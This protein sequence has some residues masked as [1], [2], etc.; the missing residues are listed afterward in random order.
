M[1]LGTGSVQSPAPSRR[2]D[3]VAV[4]AALD[5]FEEAWQHGTPPRLLD[6]LPADLETA[7][8]RDILI[9][10]IKID[11]DN[12]WRRFHRGQPKTPEKP[13][14][15]RPLPD[16]PLVED[17]LDRHAELGS[18][19]DP[20]IEL[21]REEYWVRHCYGDRPRHEDYLTRFPR[22][23]AAV[24][25]AL[26]RADAELAREPVRVPEFALAK[27]WA[28]EALPVDSISRFIE[29]LREH[30]LLKA[31]QLSQLLQDHLQG[32][33]ADCRALARALIERG[34]LTPY[35]ANQVLQGHAPSLVLGSYVLLERAG[36]GATGK[37]FKARHQGMDRVVALKVI[38]P[39]LLRNAEVVQRFYQEI[40][41]ASRM[42]HPNV[43]HAYDAG[44][45]GDT[46]FLA[47]EYVDGTNLHR[48]VEKNGPLIIE[49]ACEYLRQAALGLQHAFA[50]GMVHRD[51][52]PSNLLV[53]TSG[54]RPVVKILDLGMARWERRVDGSSNGPLT[55]DG[56]VMGTPDFMSPEQAQD[57][58]SVDIR[59]D[60]YS[61]GCTAYYLLSGHVPFPKPTFIQ[62]VD[63]QRFEE[64]HPLEDIRKDTPEWL[65][66]I[67]RRLM[68]KRPED[69]FQTPLE[70]AE[71]LATHLGV[72]NHICTGSSSETV[73]VPTPS[74]SSTHTPVPPPP[75]SPRSGFAALPLSIKL[76]L[77][78]LALGVVAIVML[79]FLVKRVPADPTGGDPSRLS[80]TTSKVLSQLSRRRN[81]R[82]TTVATLKAHHWPT[83]DN[84]KWYYAGPFENQNP[85]AYGTMYGPEEDTNIRQLRLH[86]DKKEIYKGKA[87]ATVAWKEMTSFRVGEI[88]KL[89]LYD[90]NDFACTYLY[91]AFDVREAMDLPLSL[92]SSDSL[93]VWHNGRRLYGRNGPR[94]CEPNQET[95]TLKVTPGVNELLLK[96]S[97]NKEVGALYVMP[98]LPLDWT[99]EE[100]AHPPTYLSEQPEVG[101]LVGLG[102]FGKRGDLGYEGRRIHY[103]G[104]LDPRGLSLHPP[105]NGMSR[106][107]YRV[108]KYYHVFRGAVALDDSAEKSA[109]PVTFS[110]WADGKVLWRS[111]P[112]QHS[113]EHQDFT[114]IISGV[115]AL[116]LRVHCPGKRDKARAIWLAPRL[117]D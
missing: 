79:P 55:D 63:A 108:N 96:V 29:A 18:R 77:A 109:F 37:V 106:V 102:K 97:N 69:R 23:S 67:V 103:K 76:T 15:T 90:R 52:K 13:D 3:A 10:L 89:A 92:G 44:P 111:Q 50:N 54:D 30:R 73:I 114:L 5:G 66:G 65:V 35:Q 47:M 24:R 70:L 93:E 20:P 34:W 59:S 99:I 116:E 8:R 12:R 26:A 57:A 48:L 110:V 113:G 51:I 56:T 45:I 32:V 58:R 22:Q 4:D 38:R 115:D 60:L 105:G 62:K 117:L 80:P 64:P 74:P 49:L 61:L 84:G 9:D 28:A 43:V 112:I 27:S 33:Y 101:P 98:G 71:V 31:N 83:L 11:L 100:T 42:S 87:G 91:H 40:Q 94:K 53:E 46:H 78:G 25:A 1:S 39:E 6:F 72:K 7:T 21:I 19:I 107:V 41:A 17:Y 88:N 104:E 86:I 82:E 36:E 2:K 68:A 16:R 81:I 85:R 75:A 14:S 95:L